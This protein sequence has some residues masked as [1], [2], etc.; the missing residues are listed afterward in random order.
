MAADP[1]PVPPQQE[2]SGAKARRSGL[3]RTVRRYVPGALAC[4]VLLGCGLARASVHL[5][6]SASAA[7]DQTSQS[8]ATPPDWVGKAHPPRRAEATCTVSIERQTSAGY[9]QQTVKCE[10]LVRLAGTDSLVAWIRSESLYSEGSAHD[11]ARYVVAADPSFDCPSPV[12]EYTQGA[13]TALLRLTGS[14]P[15]SAYGASYPGDP[16]GVFADSYLISVGDLASRGA[17]VESLRLTVRT[18]RATI[19]ALTG[20]P[21]RQGSD[22]AVFDGPPSDVGVV[23]RALE[24]VSVPG[25]TGGSSQ[26][27][28][29]ANFDISPVLWPLALLVPWFAL[30]ALARRSRSLVGVAM[31]RSAL[32]LLIGAPMV[33]LAPLSF[34]TPFTAIARTLLLVV[35]PALVVT[36]L[37]RNRRSLALSREYVHGL[38]AVSVAMLT[39]V[40]L[41]IVFVG[42]GTRV[43]L[44]LVGAAVAVAGLALL[45][46]FLPPSHMAHRRAWHSDLRV[47]VLAVGMATLS[48]SLADAWLDPWAP[49]NEVLVLAVLGLMW[50]PLATVGLDAALGRRS[51]SSL[52][53]AIPLTAVLFLPPTAIVSNYP[54]MAV[55]DTGYSR[56]Y[57]DLAD[58]AIQVANLLLVC[59]AIGVLRRF[60]RRPSAVVESSA[61]GA[62]VALVAVL[63][64]AWSPRS[65]GDLL[66]VIAAVLM[67]IWLAPRRRVDRA[68]PLAT[69]SEDDHSKWLRMEVHRRLAQSS[70]QDLY[71]EARAKIAANEVELAAYQKLQ[72]DL[73]DV[74]ADDSVKVTSSHGD[75]RVPLER[76]ALGTSGGRSA[77]A[78][79][80]AASGY[81][82]ALAL[83]VISYE[84]WAFYISP[85]GRLDF[86]TG[87]DLL[88]VA[89]HLLRW[90]AYGLVFGYFYP[91]IRGRGPLAKSSA[92]L[93]ALLVP[94][95]LQIATSGSLLQF[96]PP[97]ADKLVAAAIRTGQVVVF[98]LGLGLCWERRL[99]RLAGLSWSRVRNLRSIRA[100]GAP[101]TT[102]I[103]AGATAAGAALAGAAV[104]AVIA[105][106]PAQT[107]PNG[108]PTPTPPPTPTL[109]PSS[110]PGR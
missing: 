102:V 66:A 81:S 32:W 67:V 70:A 40:V 100:L 27:N 17:L 53:F 106:P 26:A 4:V 95:L 89:R 5:D 19:A 96:T 86:F 80:L 8:S 61:W 87:L 30:A 65:V 75:T 11:L 77:W 38:S 50:A 97:G 71:R 105:T 22:S 1:L 94:E 28:H 46:L 83:P 79:G 62:A 74:A 72:N 57:L 63:A 69:S 45:L 92:L 21:V 34:T 78:N 44:V 24:P 54:A 108:S 15:T 41:G 43:S 88:N 51:R 68:L 6:S 104:A 12:L 85:E 99:T 18:D 90:L 35:A 47:S 25:R 101:I 55:S 84:A 82:L 37:R 103:V 7:P 98:C 49:G 36:V 9:P 39:S 31:K 29:Q 60:G 48:A 20:T 93:V 58:S 10:W 33:W 13:S 64:C 73:D 23:A 109:S 16:S 52:I 76:A 91:L 14:Q 107:G 42:S 59:V 110:S 2:E 56:Y 3:T